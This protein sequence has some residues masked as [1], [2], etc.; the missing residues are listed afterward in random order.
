MQAHFNYFADFPF[1]NSTACVCFL[2]N[3]LPLT[4]LQ[5]FRFKI[6]QPVFLFGQ[7]V[8]FDNFTDIPF[9][10]SKACV[11]FFGVQAPFYYSARFYAL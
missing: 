7:Q 4:T 6:Q 2:G 8:A 9:Y 10:N 3:K 1:Y 5:I 11:F